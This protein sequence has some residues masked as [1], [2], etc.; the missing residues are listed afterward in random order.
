M[1]VCHS[2]VCAISTRDVAHSMP[3]QDRTAAAHRLR[4]CYSERAH[5]QR[6]GY[7]ATRVS[8]FS[9]IH[10]FILMS[11]G[12]RRILRGMRRRRPMQKYGQRCKAGHEAGQLGCENPHARDFYQMVIPMLCA[13]ISGGHRIGARPCAEGGLDDGTPFARKCALIDE[14]LPS[15]A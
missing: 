14:S 7:T 4:H 2:K 12:D 11:E 8:G 6:I 5:G 10:S 1:A 15:S 13:N 3:S 9:V